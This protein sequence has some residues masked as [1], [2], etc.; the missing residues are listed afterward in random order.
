[1][2]GNNDEVWAELHAEGL[3][4][5]AAARRAGSKV[6]LANGWAKTSGKTWAP[7]TLMGLKLA[8]MS[9][10]AAAKARG[11]NQPKDFFWVPTWRLLR[12]G[13]MSELEKHFAEKGE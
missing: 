8:G 10:A 2:S 12:L 9:A 6:A 4:A 3:T 5:K 13:E 1:M 7:D 11:E